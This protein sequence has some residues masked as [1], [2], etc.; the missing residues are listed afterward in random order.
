[1]K[2]V[3][4]GYVP[5]D[6]K[7]FSKNSMIILKKAAQN[8]QYLINQGYPIKNSSVFVGNHYNLSERQRLALV[9]SVSSE[10]QLE[11]RKQN[12]LKNLSENSIIYVDG[13]NIIITLEVAFSKS[14]IFYC[15]DGTFRDLAGLRG[16]Y[17]LIDK[18]DL[19]IHEIGQ[20][21]SRH[22]I[23]KVVFYLDAPVSN[24]GRLGVR[25]K[26]LLQNFDF[27]TEIIVINAVD[28][29]L[30]KHENVITSDAIILDNCKSWYN[31]SKEILE[32]NNLIENVYQ[33]F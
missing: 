2:T 10:K 17:R 14:P 28:Y 21:L 22:R 7:F 29:E 19:A 26:E 13:F 31:L 23:Q 16:T 15:M 1:M 6:E 12:E 3:A 11:T 8:I 27:E 25:I 32:D 4:R 30:K 9:R 20:A 33:L 5:E 24:S 18:T